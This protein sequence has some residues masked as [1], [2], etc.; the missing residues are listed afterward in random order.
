MSPESEQIHSLLALGLTDLEARIYVFLL[1]TNLATGYRIAKAINR[2]AANTYE[3]IRSLQE[4]GALVVAEGKKRL[5]SP[6]PQDQFLSQIKGQFENQLA[7]AE[8]SLKKTQSA[9]DER[10]IFQIR[11]VEQVMERSKLILGEAQEV[12]L[13]D[14][15]PQVIGRLSSDIQSAAKRGV[16]V[17]VKTYEPTRIRG[18]KNVC[19]PR[20]SQLL[21][22]YPGEWLR[23]VADGHEHLLAYL[24]HNCTRVSHA[25][26]STNCFLSLMEHF[27]LWTEHHMAKLGQAIDT[28]AS[29]KTVSRILSEHRRSRREKLSGYRALASGLMPESGVDPA[30]PVRKKEEE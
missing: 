9:M 17:Y 22:V 20:S 23:I 8:A 19:D 11:N 1:S 18:A 5:C 13:V 4:K 30:K 24:T 25:F 16:E 7:Q 3:A 10:R 15:F 14:A 6:V 27:D 29:Q 21:S 2:P 26:F 12:I 28:G